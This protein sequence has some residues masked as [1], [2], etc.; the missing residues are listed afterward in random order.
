[1]SYS[2]ISTHFTLLTFLS[3]GVTSYCKL[4]MTLLAFLAVMWERSLHSFVKAGIVKAYEDY[5]ADSC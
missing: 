1:M 5:R 3:S 4:S 2:H